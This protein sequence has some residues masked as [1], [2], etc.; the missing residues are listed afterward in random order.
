MPPLYKHYSDYDGPWPWPHFTPAEI[1][2]KHC[3]EMYLDTASMDA[4]ERLRASW[5]QAIILNSAHRCVTHNKAVDGTP[6]SQH[7]KIAFDCRCPKDQQA[8]FANAARGAGFG[9]I[10]YYPNRGFVHIDIVPRKPWRE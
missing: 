2:C 8:A 10:G 9:G 4:L 5:G 3:G 7:L 6:N 1:S